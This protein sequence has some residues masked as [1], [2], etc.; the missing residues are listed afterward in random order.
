M[1]NERKY[2][3]VGMEIDWIDRVGILKFMVVYIDFGG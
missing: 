1:V 3:F 2:D